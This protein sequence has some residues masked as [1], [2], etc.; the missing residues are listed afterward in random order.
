MS[1][2]FS[3]VKPLK[4]EYFDLG[5]GSWSITLNE[6]TKDKY[7]LTNKSILNKNELFKRFIKYE[8]PHYEQNYT[9]KSYLINLVD[10]IIDWIGEDDVVLLGDEEFTDA[11][12][13][14][15]GHEEMC[16]ALN[17]KLN[18]WIDAFY[19]KTGTRYMES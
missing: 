1:V 8:Y 9:M 15:V 14:E 12:F 3:L 13:D 11:V 19:K 16:N 5:K 4:H 7:Q 10:K 6:L 2:E 18:W 17:K